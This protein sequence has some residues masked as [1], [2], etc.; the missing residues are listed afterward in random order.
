M[1]YESQV[2]NPHN[3]RSSDRRPKIRL[4]KDIRYSIASKLINRIGGDNMIQGMGMTRQEDTL[5]KR[6]IGLALQLLDHINTIADP[7]RTKSIMEIK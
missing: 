7:V 2:R 3:S 1:G 5:F 6:K 4:M